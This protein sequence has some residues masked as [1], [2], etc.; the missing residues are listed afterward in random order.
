[1]LPAARPLLLT[2][3]LALLPVAVGYWV[4]THAPY[5]PTRA[6]AAGH[7]TRACALHHCSHATP[8]NSRAYSQLRPVYDATMRALA[9]GGR[10]WY[11]ATNVAVYLGLLP[12][13]LV[14]LTYGVLRNEQL[15]QKLKQRP[16]V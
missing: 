2:L 12:L 3:L 13:L 8:A 1:M 5:P 14:W 7:C 4:N 15:I 10:G 11:A 9:T 16:R 6:H